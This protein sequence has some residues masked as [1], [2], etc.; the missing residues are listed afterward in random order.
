MENSLHISLSRTQRTYHNPFQ[1][2]FL[3]SCQFLNVAHFLFRSLWNHNRNTT[4]A[5]AKNTDFYSLW[6]S[7]L[8]EAGGVI[9]SIFFEAEL[10]GID[11]KKQMLY[12]KTKR[13]LTLALLHSSHYKLSKVDD[14][15]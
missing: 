4:P 6:C 15:L 3:C 10:I 13:R 5:P 11:M 9:C 7:L 8:P 1:L 14:F 12:D 2:F